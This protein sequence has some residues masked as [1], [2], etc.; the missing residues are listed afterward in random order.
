MTCRRNRISIT[1]LPISS[2]TMDLSSFGAGAADVRPSRV[3]TFVTHVL[4]GRQGVLCRHLEANERTC[5]RWCR[6]LPHLLAPKGTGTY[7]LGGIQLLHTSNSSSEDRLT[8]E[9]CKMSKDRHGVHLDLGLSELTWR[10]ADR[11]D[12]LAVLAASD[13]GCDLSSLPRPINKF[14]MAP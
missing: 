9:G 6:C 14:T 13:E 5:A 10:T 2:T 12:L 1:R 7:P 8:R 4:L 11:S 3:N